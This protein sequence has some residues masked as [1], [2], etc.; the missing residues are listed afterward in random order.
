MTAKR[1]NSPFDLC[2]CESSDGPGSFS[3]LFRCWLTAVGYRFLLTPII[4]VYRR[5]PGWGD[6]PVPWSDQ[7]NPAE[8]ETRKKAGGTS[9]SKNLGWPTLLGS[10]VWAVPLFA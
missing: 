8:K 9:Y 4:P 10:K 2:K 7:E 1:A 6:I 5:P 3:F